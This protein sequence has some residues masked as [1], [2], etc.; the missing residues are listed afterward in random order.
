MFIIITCSL[1][2][3][4]HFLFQAQENKEELKAKLKEI[5]RGKSDVFNSENAEDDKVSVV[6]Y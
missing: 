1:G 5:I 3:H 2:Y 4:L 6:F